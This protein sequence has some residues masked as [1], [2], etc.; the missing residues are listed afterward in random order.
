MLV[1]WIIKMSLVQ[2]YGKNL[3][4]K[5]YSRI[6]WVYLVSVLGKYYISPF[7]V[8]EKWLVRNQDFSLKFCM[9]SFACLT[10]YLLVKWKNYATSI[11]WAKNKL[12]KIKNALPVF[13]NQIINMLTLFLTFFFNFELKFLHFVWV[14]FCYLINFRVQKC[15]N[16][17]YFNKRRFLKSISA[18]TKLKIK[19][20]LNV[21]WKFT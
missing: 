12:F 10:F 4:I 6:Q 9:F 16:F 5:S 11:M 18:K 3:I 7:V 1:A 17:T 19:L 13:L 15:S 20:K 21:I 14:H 2:S 8:I